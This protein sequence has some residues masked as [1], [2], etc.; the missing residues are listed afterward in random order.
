[1]NRAIDV[2]TEMRKL[3]N[4]KPLH[5]AAGAGVLASQALRELPAL[6]ARWRPEAYVTSLPNRASEVVTTARAKAARGYDHL[7]VRGER[8]LA[9]KGTP[10][11]KR[12]AGAKSIAA[13][14]SA[15]A[16]NTAPA[17]NT[18]AIKNAAA[19]KSSAAAKSTADGS[20]SAGSKGTAR[21]KSARNGK[22]G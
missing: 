1:M 21:G 5:A 13:D 10:G 8:V 20:G 17:K 9:G 19:A 2:P 12:A 15:A 11:A 4:S 16:K 14:S 3:T 6:I 22:T 18:A 7:A